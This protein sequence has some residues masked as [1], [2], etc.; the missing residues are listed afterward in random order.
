M[1]N[2]SQLGCEKSQPN[3]SKQYALAGANNANNRLIVN[4]TN[5][6]FNNNNRINGNTLRPFLEFD[7]KEATRPD[8]LVTYSR[9]HAVHRR[10]R[11]HKASKRSVLEFEILIFANIERVADSVENFEYIPRASTTFIVTIPKTR[12]VIAAYFGDREVQTY[13]VSVIEYLLNK[14]LNEHSYACRV[15]KG[16]LK[17]IIHLQDVIFEATNGYTEDAWVFAKDL[18]SFFMNIDT[19]I[20][21][22]R[23]IKFIEENYE[24]ADKELIIYL[25]RIIYQH[26]PQEGALVHSPRMMWQDIPAEKKL[27]GRTG[28]IGIPIGDLTSQIIALFVTTLYIHHIQQLAVGVSHYTD[29]T[30]GVTRTKELFL[31][32][33]RFINQYSKD[34]YGLIVNEKKFYCQHYT[35]GIQFLGFKIKRD[36]LLPSDRIYHNFTW[37]V[38]R[39]I[40]RADTFEYALHNKEKFQCTINSYLG[41]LKWCNAYKLRREQVKKIQTSQWANV[42]DFDS[43]YLVVRIKKKYGHKVQNRRNGKLIKKQIIYDY[44]RIEKSAC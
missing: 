43:K 30:A 11:R 18:R 24:G 1:D 8:R 22:E 41:L 44:R 5:G 27:R 38:E 7:F 28:Y 25:T 2:V 19:K 37:K 31:S 32:Q 12:E 3:N 13:Y 15:G 29:D 9:W 17:A 20:W 6:R 34:E 36:R 33:Q 26:Q 14:Y 42:Y 21:T 23:L 4:G 40:R 10:C 35:K 39:M 16:T